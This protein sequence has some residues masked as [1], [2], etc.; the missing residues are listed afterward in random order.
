MNRRL[1]SFFIIIF[2][3]V[4]CQQPKTSQ[5]NKSNEAEA[6][7]TDPFAIISPVEQQY[8][9]LTFGDIKPKGW[10]LNQMSSDLEKGFVGNLDQLVPD[11]IIE[12][13]IYGEDRLT[14]DVKSKDVGATSNN[15]EW[16]VQFLW[17]NSETQSNWWDGFV[18]HAILTENEEALNKTKDYIERM[19][20]YQDEDGYIGIYAPDLRYNFNS[21]NGELWA[22][23]SL[24]RAMLAYYEATGDKEVLNA[25]EKAVQV[26]MDAYSPHNSDP[27]N[28]EKPFGGLEHGLTITD[29]FD[30]LYQLTGKK[31]YLDYAHW[32]YENFS[33]NEVG[34]ED[35]QY[36][37][38]I[39]SSYRFN[40]HGVHTY[41][42][43]RP[44]V[45]A[46]YAS[47]NA[48]LKNAISGYMDK[49]NLV[50]TPSGGPIGDEWIGKRIA[51][52][53]NIGYE[54]C[55]VHELLD[56][57]SQLL[58]KSGN[59]ELAD[60][61][62]WLLFNA[63]Q[64]ARHPDE[65][66]IAYLKTDNSFAMNGKRPP[67]T[68]P[69]HEETRYKYSPVHKDAAVCCVPNAGRIYPYYTKAMWMKK[70]DGLI[71]T[72][73]GP[74]E[75]NT[76]INGVSVKIIE[77]TNYPFELGATFSVIVE[78]PVEFEISFRKPN[79]AT[80]ST[81]KT[82]GASFSED[83]NQ[84][85]ARKKWS[86]QTDIRLEFSADVEQHKDSTGEY[87]FSYGP[88]VYALPLEGDAE[89]VKEFD[90]NDFKNLHYDEAASYDYA[91][92]LEDTS[93]FQYN[94]AGYNAEDIWE[95]EVSISGKLWNN[96]T[97]SYEQVRLVPMGNTILRRVTFPAKK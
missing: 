15:E 69:G 79:W 85:T 74:S 57:Y 22:Q 68:G 6:T 72:L 87:Y 63:G 33:V 11:L 48:K 23:A 10:L 40:S 42:H 58:Q 32:L 54:Y 25:L 12:D 82:D 96:T 49:L 59:L 90:I 1:I 61:I 3:S 71:A 73:Y 53:T 66:S 55:S 27:F 14:K 78:Q 47:G 30:R 28:V 86:G 16:E 17:W 44:L 62:E 2:T 89:V 64:G 45:T 34:Q 94:H 52:P 18:R 19:M 65:H 38:L 43:L 9:W 76:T 29:T 81:I 20:S 5:E 92:S 51:D 93:K 91:V 46:Y 84:I 35:A 50:L 7:S 97:E 67:V 31:E 21:E 95:T 24:F 36:A 75:I 83:K 41:E 39:D 8:E 60:R 13:E 26:T 37:H 70:E 56:S 4:A 80:A 77:K 88:L